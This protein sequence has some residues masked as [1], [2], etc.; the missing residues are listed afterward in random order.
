[1][2]CFIH[3][4]ALLALVAGPLAAHAQ[5]P[6]PSGNCNNGAVTH[7][8]GGDCEGGNCEGGRGGLIAKLRARCES[9]ECVP[10]TYGDP[11]LFYNFWAGP[12]C[13]GVAAQ[14]YL[15]PHPVPAYVGH[16]FYTYQPLMPHEMLYTHGRRYHRYY[17]EGRGLNRT[18]VMWT[19][20]PGYMAR[21]IVGH[22]SIPR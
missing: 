17:D 18:S 7:E 11:D 9:G 15:A 22:F 10:H 21:N 1:M 2:R 13:D 20:S 16:T 19:K 6:C 4:F 14:L 3:G 12:N 8:A 5:E